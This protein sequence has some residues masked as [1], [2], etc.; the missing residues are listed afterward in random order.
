MPR[1]G[2]GVYDLPTG[3][4]AET[5]ETIE[6]SQHNLPLE[7]LETDMN[8]ARPVVAGG[9]GSTTAAGARSNLGVASEVST[10]SGNYTVVA[11]DRGKLIRCTANLTLSLTAAA[12]LGSDFLFMVKA[13]G[14]DVTIDPDGSETI[15]GAA[16]KVVRDG[17]SVDVWCNGTAFFTTDRPHAMEFIASADLSNDATAEFTGVDATKYDAYE[18]VLQNVIPATDDV[19]LLMRTSSDGGNNYDSGPSDYSYVTDQIGAANAASSNGTTA[20][21]ITNIGGNDVGSA[22]GEDGVSMTIRIL[23]PHLAKKTVFTWHGLF[24]NSVGNPIGII[25]SG[26]RL[27]SADVDAVQFLFDS[28]NL[29]SGTITFY[30]LRNA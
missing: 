8:T 5:G 16:T 17:T 27:S 18:I 13:D 25:G 30:G 11:A 6:A 14:G 26:A 7:D 12:T 20:M 9:T 1:N 19:R 10:K 23:G 4:L 24:F 15:D 22:A 28:G 3:Y 21:I 29:E 2:S